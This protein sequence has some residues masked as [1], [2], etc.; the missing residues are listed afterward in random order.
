[1][2]LSNPDGQQLDFGER[3]VDVVGNHELLI[4]HAIER[5]DQTGRSP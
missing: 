1:M 3:H 4:E 2:V 5:G